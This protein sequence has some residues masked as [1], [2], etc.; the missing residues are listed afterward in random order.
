M[1]KFIFLVLVKDYVFFMKITD[2]KN[3]LLKHKFNT[4]VV[5]SCFKKI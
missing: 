1:I 5:M 4:V 2:V 3:Y